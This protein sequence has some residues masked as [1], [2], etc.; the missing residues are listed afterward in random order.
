MPIWVHASRGKSALLSLESISIKSNTKLNLYLQRGK[1]T[2]KHLGCWQGCWG[3]LNLEWYSS[4]GAV[5]MN[6][7]GS[8]LHGLLHMRSAQLQSF[9]KDHPVKGCLNWQQS[10]EHPE[11]KATQMSS[12]SLKPDASQTCFW[13]RTPL[14]GNR[15]YPGP[16]SWFS[17][18]G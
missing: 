7:K 13:K 9:N 17:R 15:M 10:T 18:M 2:D 5:S 1:Q 14:L 4:S 8:S 16:K 6:S 3:T 11:Q 12:L